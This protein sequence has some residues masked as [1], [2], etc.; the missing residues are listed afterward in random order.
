MV[1]FLLSLPDELQQKLKI[2]AKEQGQ[3]LNAL[4]RQIIW[5]W[6]SSREE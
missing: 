5:E 4:I 2:I 6:I 3:T 1:R